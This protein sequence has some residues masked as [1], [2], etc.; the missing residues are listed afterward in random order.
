MD[1]CRE[2]LWN[3]MDLGGDKMYPMNMWIMWLGC[4][5]ERELGW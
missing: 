2:S 1:I 3:L 5:K 4:M